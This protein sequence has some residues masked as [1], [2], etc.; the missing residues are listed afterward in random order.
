MFILYAVC[1][2]KL[3]IFSFE[4]TLYYWTS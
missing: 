4:C 1:L 3:V 2:T